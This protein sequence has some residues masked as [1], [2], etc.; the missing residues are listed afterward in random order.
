M[1]KSLNLALM[2]LLEL[3][4][5]VSVAYWGFTA[6]DNWA[7]RLLAAVGGVVVFAVVWSAFGSP[8]ARVPVHRGAGRVVLELVW[9]GGGF[10]LLAAAGA[11]V[12]ALVLAV[13]FVVNALLRWRWRQSASDMAPGRAA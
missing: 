13:L 10:A 4:V 6:S 11:T 2:F 8:K 9:F 3:A 1:A 7:L 12:A 5:Y